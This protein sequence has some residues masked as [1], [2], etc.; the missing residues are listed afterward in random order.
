MRTMTFTIEGMHCVSCGLLVD[1]CLLDVDGVR[2]ARTD[3]RS[4]RCEVTVDEGVPVADLLAA[5][6]EAGYTGLPA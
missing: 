2:T 4:A 1:D 3:M 5:I 6:T